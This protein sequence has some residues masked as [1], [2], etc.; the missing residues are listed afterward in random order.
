MNAH[1]SV[2]TSRRCSRPGWRPFWRRRGRLRR[3][4]ARPSVVHAVPA[5]AASTALRAS[6]AR[7]DRHLRRAGR[8][9]RPARRGAR[10]RQRSA[11]TTASALR[12]LPPRRRRRR[13][14]RLR[15]ELGL[16]RTSGGCSSSKASRCRS[17]TSS[18]HE[19]AA[20]APDRAATGSRSSPRSS[21]PPAASTCAAAARL[22][23][24]LDLA[25]SAVARR[26]FSLL[27]DLGVRVGDPHLPPPRV[28]PGDPLPAPRRGRRAGARTCSARRACSVAPAPRS[29]ARR[30]ASS[31]RACCRGAYL[32]GA[33]L[34][35]G[36]LSGPRAPHL[37]IRT[38]ALDGA[39]S[40][41]RSRARDGDRRCASSSAARH[42]VALRQG[43]RGDRG[44]LLARRRR[45]D[46]AR[47]RGAR[48][49]RRHPRARQ[50]ARQRRPR[51]PRPR[52]PRRARASSTRSAGSPPTARSTTL[53]PPLQRGRRAPPAAPVAVAARARAKC[54]PADHQGRSCTAACDRLAELA[55]KRDERVSGLEPPMTTAGS[56]RTCGWAGPRS[57]G[58]GFRPR[59]SPRSGARC[60]R[61]GRSSS[62]LP[63]RPALRL[64]PCDRVAEPTVPRSPCGEVP[65]RVRA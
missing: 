58:D 2:T 49:P 24:H 9:R 37:E 17:L 51:Q 13:P 6:P 64:T 53:P 65:S 31:R 55:R 26:A 27:R 48:G 60:T 30:G 23:A 8:A 40:S 19:L 5:R 62:E 45:R 63:L 42:A 36:S 59:P 47:A 12:A 56:L 25:S 15:L 39:G 21:T 7:R 10:G 52:E 44:L 57:S 50:P 14:R 35:G 33:L 22:A 3:C 16:G 1:A 28:R 46:R 32:R 29:S 43:Q 4:R 20:I 61:R 41:P 38:A 18:A 34:G 54:R 11:R